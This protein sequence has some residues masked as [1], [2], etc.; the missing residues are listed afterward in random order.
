MELVTVPGYSDEEKKQI[1]T[2][3]LLP[4]QLKQHGLEV[5]TKWTSLVKTFV[6]LFFFFV[7][8]GWCCF[9]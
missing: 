3:H 2:N 1:L 8:L 4:K 5:C 7:C 9:F 6:S